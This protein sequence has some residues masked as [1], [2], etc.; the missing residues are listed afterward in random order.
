MFSKIDIENLVNSVHHT[1]SKSKEEESDKRVD[2]YLA[3]NSPFGID[4]VGYN[5]EKK[6]VEHNRT[7]KGFKGIEN[8][9]LRRN[10][11]T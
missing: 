10:I 9:D 6:A 11:L 5:K 3:E 8:N 7:V 4:G 2:H 1:C